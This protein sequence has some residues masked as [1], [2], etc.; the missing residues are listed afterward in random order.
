MG[1]PEI[2]G[3]ADA[4]RA[5]RY[6]GIRTFARLPTFEEVGRADVAVLG[7]PFDSAT[8]FRPGARFGPAAVRDASILLRPYH[9]PLDVEVFA[10]HQVVDAGD[11]PADPIDVGGGPRCHPRARRG[12]RLRRRTG[13]RHRRRPLGGAAAD[14]RGGRA[15]RAAVSDPVRRALRH[16][17]R[18]L[19][20]PHHARDDHATC[21]GGGHRR[22]R[23][24]HADRHSGPALRR[25][26]PRGRA[27]ARVHRGHGCASSAG[28]TSRTSS[29][30]P[31]AG[32]ATPST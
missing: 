26:R 10:V 31:G 3:P 9:E 15:S 25:E 2:R 24:L 23:A 16:V 7:A 22:R 19:R 14:A 32:W 29:P 12:A 21:G 5:P 18:V 8:S 28:R 4:L 6:A 30:T 1:T 20:P 17:G 13:A 11:A 27:V